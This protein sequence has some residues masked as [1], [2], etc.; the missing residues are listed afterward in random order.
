MTG[1]IHRVVPARPAFTLVELLVT[2][3]VVV[4]LGAVGFAVGKPAIA[5][6]RQ[7]ACLNQLRGIGVA[8]EGYL[9]DH[10]QFL[11][12]MAAARA[13]RSADVPA[14][15][16]VLRPYLEPD[17]AFRCPAG[18]EVHA[19]SGSSYLWNSTQNG[20]HITK[21]NFFGLDERPERIPLVS[22]KESW[23]PDGVNYLYAD[24][25]SSSEVRFA[26]GR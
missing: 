3:G 17:D 11:P 15:D 10:N 2:I 18:H 4:V 25:S 13:N 6:S 8:L 5:R 20:L 22:D 26:T 24:R 14:I 23:H 9:Q 12:E 19:E 16:T 1:C 21:L 7:A